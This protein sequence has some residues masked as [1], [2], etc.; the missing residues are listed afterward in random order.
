MSTV[1]PE[2]PNDDKPIHDGAWLCG[3]CGKT[4]RIALEHIID[5]RGEV[6][7]T[8]TRQAHTRA[9]GGRID[10]NAAALTVKADPPRG[11]RYMEP[12]LANEAAAALNLAA[13]EAAHAVDNA[14]T[15]WARTLMETTG[16]T[17]PE[18]GRPMPGQWR[19]AT[20]SWPTCEVVPANPTAR[21]ALLLWRHVEWWRHRQEG[22]DFLSEMLDAEH[23][24]TRAVDTTARE[25][26]RIGTCPVEWPNTDGIDEVC[27][28]E[29]RAWPMPAV[30]TLRE[31]FD[32]RDVQRLPKC[33]RCE[34]EADVSWW[35]RE[36]VPELSPRVTA[37]ELIG[38]IAFELH[39]PV[40]HEQIRQWAHRDKI[41][42][43]DKDSKGRNLY[44]HT[45]V[46]AAIRGDVERQQAKAEEV[47]A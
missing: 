8:I 10:P 41:R 20:G 33:L 22:P 39:W 19:A 7:A 14:V 42:V 3:D 38:V 36:M 13:S 27:G 18:P 4:L 47:D 34:T 46:I 6:E 11:S 26:M 32:L 44:D 15:T 1:L 2:C 28:G 45:E 12:P 30:A 40:T 16:A 21:A 24:L 23:R 29:V 25:S 37:T 43:V 17:L 9:G 5:L 35:L 31:L